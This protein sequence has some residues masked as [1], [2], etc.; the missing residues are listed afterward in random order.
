M[1]VTVVTLNGILSPTNVDKI[2]SMHVGYLCLLSCHMYLHIMLMWPSS[3]ADIM[4]YQS[5]NFWKLD[6][7]RFAKWMVT[8]DP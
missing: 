5:S 6:A 8:Q 3:Q 1:P 7:T 2:S 4:Y